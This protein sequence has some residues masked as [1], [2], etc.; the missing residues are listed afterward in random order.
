M[1]K[2]FLNIDFVLV[3]DTMVQNHSK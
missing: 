1:Q 2:W 3:I